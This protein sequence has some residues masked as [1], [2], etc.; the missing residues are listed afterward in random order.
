MHNTA[1]HCAGRVNQ[2]KQ[3]ASKNNDRL[4]HLTS[5]MKV[6]KKNANQSNSH[7]K[8]LQR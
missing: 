1:Q 2:V 3:I 4:L 7:I 8:L 6:L 5:Q